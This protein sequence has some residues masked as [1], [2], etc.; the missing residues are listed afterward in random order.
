MRLL[1]MEWGKPLLRLIFCLLSFSLLLFPPPLLLFPPPL[2]S[3]LLLFFPP[4]LSPLLLSPPPLLF[5]SLYLKKRNPFN[6]LCE[7]RS[8]KGKV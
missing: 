2:A 8:L 1:N 6:R 4:L 5:C 3:P 7:P